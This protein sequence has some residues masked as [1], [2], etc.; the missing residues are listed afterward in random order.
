MKIDLTKEESEFILSTLDN[1]TG[2][3]VLPPDDRFRI[4]EIIESIK[5]KL[6]TDDFS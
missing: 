6:K 4:R 3:N 5:K 1:I 2:L